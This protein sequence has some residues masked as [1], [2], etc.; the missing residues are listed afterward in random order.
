MSNGITGF[1]AL[2][3]AVL[4][5]FLAA[6]EIWKSRLQIVATFGS[7]GDSSRVEII[8]LSAKS[9]VVRYYTLYWENKP[10]KTVDLDNWDMRSIQLKPFE[11]FCL[12]FADEHSIN[13]QGHKQLN[14]QLEI[15]GRWRSKKIKL[16]PK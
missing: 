12:E 9:V 13:L 5:T 14:I 1:I 6:R 4:S 8:N 11:P 3:G 16:W 2:W 7:I 10:S 15:A